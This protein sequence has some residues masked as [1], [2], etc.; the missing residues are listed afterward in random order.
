MIKIDDKEYFGII[1][2]IENTITHCIY[3]G[4]TT[5]PKGFNGRYY[6]KGKGIE[7][8]YHYLLNNKKQGGSYNKY[9]LRSIEKCGFDA[10][11]VDEIID[12][13]LTFE[14]LNEKETY[15]INKYDSYK[16]GY[17]MSCG[18]DSVS[19][20]KRPR[21]KDCPNSK[22]VCQIGLD[23]KLIKIWDS[24]T[25]ASK[26]LNINLATISDVCKGKRKTAGK[27]VW[28]QEKDFDSNYDYSR[29]P[30]T[31][32]RGRGTKPVV[33]LS[34]TGEIIETFY[35]VN[36]AGKQLGISGQDVT[37]ICSNQKSKIKLNL[38]Y[39]DEYIEEQRLNEEGSN[40]F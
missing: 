25:E 38:R 17:N 29:T 36:Y 33:L 19:G 15:Y 40:K 39:K 16:N 27:Y 11:V 23:G 28:V 32:D 9:L 37:R 6:H 8:V 1:Y 5:H 22:R 31:K 7:R 13:A 10:F 24:Q 12:K 20:I 14:E 4:Q 34:E 26:E 35:S 21:G 2:K 18:G 3:I 30:S